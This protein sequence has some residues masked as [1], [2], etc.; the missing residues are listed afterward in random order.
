MTRQAPKDA[1]TRTRWTVTAL[2]GPRDIW[3]GVRWDRSVS[4][5][6][7]GQPLVRHLKVYVCLVPCMLVLIHRTTPA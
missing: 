7:Q 2:W 3:V 6:D 1:P 4:Y 5:G